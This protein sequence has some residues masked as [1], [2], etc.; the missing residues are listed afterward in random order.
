MSHE[1]TILIHSSLKTLRTVEELRAALVPDRWAGL[2]IGLVPTMGALHEGHLSLIARAR[3]QCDRV[4][5]SLFVNP[6]QFNERSDLERYPRQMQHDSN[7]A[8]EVGADLL[9]PGCDAL[10]VCWGCQGRGYLVGRK[11]VDGSAPVP[12]RPGPP[13]RANEQGCYAW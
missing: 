7:L 3:E 2:T 6:A 4:I 1:Q 11:A 5:V 12:R 10:G 8:A 9:F 13:S